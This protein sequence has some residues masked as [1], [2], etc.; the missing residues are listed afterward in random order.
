MNFIQT[1][2]EGV[3]VIEPRI[4]PDPRGCFFESYRKDFFRQN[5]IPDDFVQ[6][7]NSVSARGVLRGLHFQI[8]PKAQAKLI[9]VVRG[10]VY[11]VAVDLR[12][13]SKTYARYFGT[14]LSGENRK[15]LYIPKGFAHGFCVLEDETEFFYKCSEFYSPEHERGIIWNDPE[16]SIAWPRLDCDFILSEKDCHYPTLKNFGRMAKS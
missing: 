2:I 16:I 4:F 8:E 13:G 14:V 6:D 7:N 15:M 3:V 10:S 5:G 9:R 11:D 12:Q 1:E